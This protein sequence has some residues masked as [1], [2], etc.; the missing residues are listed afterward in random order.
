MW[1][2]RLREER[3]AHRGVK[4]EAACA[5]CVLLG[6]RAFYFPAPCCRYIELLGGGQR[7][8]F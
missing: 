1:E 6:V 3:K 2:F 4:K 5:P 7:M 8:V